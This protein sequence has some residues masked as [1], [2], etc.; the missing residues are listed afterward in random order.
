M[1][2]RTLRPYL[3]AIKTGLTRAGFFMPDSYKKRTCLAHTRHK[4]GNNFLCRETQEKILMSD[5]QAYEKKLEAQIDEWNADIDKLKAKA[6]KA[7]ADA[8]ANYE[9]EID[10]LESR[11]DDMNEKLE[12]LKSASEDAWEDVKGG[13]ESAWKSMSDAVSSAASRF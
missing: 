8:E 4:T 12:E 1:H 6:K 3:G 7:S 2:L 10:K 13:A 5:K 9:K 11:R